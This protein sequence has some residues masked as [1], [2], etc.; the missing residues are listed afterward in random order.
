MV[1]LASVAVS[2]HLSSGEP[3]P[4]L[5]S[6]LGLSQRSMISPA[7]VGTMAVTCILALPRGA[8]AQHTRALS[9]DV[10]VGLESVRTS[11]EYRNPQQ[12]SAVDALLALRLGTARRGAIITGVGA[13]TPWAW[14]S[15][16]I[17][18]PASTG[19]CIPTY[20]QFL[21]LGALVGWENQSTT[22]RAMGGPAHVTAD[23]KATFG[24]QARLDGAV[25]I[26]Q[27]FALAASVRGTMVPNY[28]GDAFQVYS[29]GVGI[30]LR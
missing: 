1:W 23:G 4:Q 20:P 12:G 16:D 6:A 24:F 26:A 30:R 7:L 10:N 27:R 29:F 28:R 17:C 13:G 2:E 11:G 25:P 5:S 9:L 15:T 22:F 21:R 3:A 18:L 14:S 8:G 19:G